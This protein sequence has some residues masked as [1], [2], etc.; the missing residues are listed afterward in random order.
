M[1]DGE[2]A[3]QAD[4]PEEAV[5]ET[6]STEA[7]AAVEHEEVQEGPAQPEADL[8]AA[9]DTEEDGEQLFSDVFGDGSMVVQEEVY[10]APPPATEPPPAASSVGPERVRLGTAEGELH[11]VSIEVVQAILGEEALER[12]GHLLGSASV[13]DLQKRMRATDGRC[14]PMIFTNNGPEKAP[15]LFSGL[16]SFAA[17]KNIGLA[18]VSV[19][20]IEPTDVGAVQGWLS[21]QIQTTT[22]DDDLIHRVHTHYD[23]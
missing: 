22:D 5:Q 18:E 7:T 4:Q 3:E 17:A 19:I 12:V 16:E 10:Q 8:P 6:S 23:D 20:T 2:P 15:T 13:H 14:T 9:P 1:F 11:R 21:Q